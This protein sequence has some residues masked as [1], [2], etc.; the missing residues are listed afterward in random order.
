MSHVWLSVLLGLVWAKSRKNGKYHGQLGL[1]IENSEDRL[2][3][4]RGRQPLQGDI[5]GVAFQILEEGVPE[6]W[7]S[8]DRHPEGEGAALN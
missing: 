4:E 5:I 3:V 7:K 2:P 1:G 8:S 6:F